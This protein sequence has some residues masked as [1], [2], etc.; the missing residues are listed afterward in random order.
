MSF[1]SSIVTY[2]DEI[3]PLSAQEAAFT[4]QQAEENGCRVMLDIG[5]GSGALAYAMTPLLKRIDAFDYDLAMVNKALS[6]RSHPIIHYRQGDMRDLAEMYVPAS[7][8]LISCYGNTLVHLPQEEALAVLPQVYD[9]LAEGGVFACQILNYDHI[10]TGNITEL[11]LVER[12]SLRFER[13]YELMSLQEVLFHSRLTLK[14][15]D[16][17]LEN[18]I[19]LYPLSKD[20]LTAGLKQAGFAHLRW[21]SNFGGGAYHGAH[22]PLIVTARK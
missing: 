18:V 21:Y 22:L 16:D 17:P 11:P 13:W 9:L 3:F 4:R 6:L 14:D 15:N 2:Y 5:C 10:F 8:D 1:Y 20:E 19:S 7:F 12:P